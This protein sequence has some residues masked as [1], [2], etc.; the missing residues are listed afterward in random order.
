MFVSF[1]NRFQELEQKHRDAVKAVETKADIVNQANKTKTLGVF[2]GSNGSAELDVSKVKGDRLRV[3]RNGKKIG[4]L[5]GTENSFVDSNVVDGSK[6]DYSVVGINNDGKQVDFTGV[7]FTPCADG[8]DDR[9][10]N[11]DATVEDY[12]FDNKY[13]FTH[14]RLVSDLLDLDNIPNMEI[15]KN[16]L[17]I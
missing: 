3:L 10:L 12:T 4:S 7:S 6:Y 9:K 17:K 13:N 16:N 8:K 2:D 14:I 15:I 5:L 1:F 11:F